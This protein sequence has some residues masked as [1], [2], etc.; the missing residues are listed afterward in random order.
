MH[1]FSPNNSTRFLVHVAIPSYD[2]NQSLLFYRDVLGATLS[3]SMNDRLTFGLHN[4]QLVCHLSKPPDHPSELSFYPRHFG[5]TFFEADLFHTFYNHILVNFPK[6]IYAE[7]AIR[8]SGR[9]DEHQTFIL[10]DPSK[11]FVEFKY[12]NDPSS[13]F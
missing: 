5:L 1:F 11:N 9:I 10:L 13:S 2:L 4:L 7:K 12:Y 3:R 6:F 8:F